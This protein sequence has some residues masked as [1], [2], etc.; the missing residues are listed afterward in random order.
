M[1]PVGQRGYRLALWSLLC[2]TVLGAL[3][4][5]RGAD[6]FNAGMMI[7][8]ILGTAGGASAARAIGEWQARAKDQSSIAEQTREP[9]P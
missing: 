3:A 9:K 8:G 6:L 2:G 5:W 4:I 7:G 1:P